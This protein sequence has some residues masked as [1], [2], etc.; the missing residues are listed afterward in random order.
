MTMTN[1]VRLPD[2][3]DNNPELKARLRRADRRA[4]AWHNRNLKRHGKAEM[5]IALAFCSALSQF[6]ESV[7][8]NGAA[9]AWAEGDAG[10]L[11]DAAWAAVYC[12]VELMWPDAATLAKITG[13]QL[14]KG[15]TYSNAA[16]VIAKWFEQM[17]APG[18][19]H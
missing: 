18:A 6:E 10:D 1:I 5:S 3:D 15:A 13:V 9:A 17:D 7:A 19:R 12:K 16:C 2:P 4:K 8:E 14:K 11:F